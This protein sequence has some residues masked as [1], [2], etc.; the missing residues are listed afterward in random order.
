[1]PSHSKLVR[2]DFRSSTV[3]GIKARWSTIF[4][5]KKKLMAPYL[6]KKHARLL[7]QK[8]RKEDLAWERSRRE[9]VKFS[10]NERFP[11]SLASITSSHWRFVSMLSCYN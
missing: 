10:Y 11:C 5:T 2:Y 4:V 8:N 6:A 3:A 7:E 1:M 9:Q